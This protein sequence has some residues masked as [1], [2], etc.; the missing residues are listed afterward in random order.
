MTYNPSYFIDA[1]KLDH[2]RM[3]VPGTEYVYS[4]LTARGSR[5][6]GVDKVLFF[7]LQ[8]FLQ[9]VLIDMFDEWF[10]RDEDDVA[11]E[12]ERRTLGVIG[13]ND[14][15]VEHIRALHRLGY[16][17]LR[18]NAIPEGTEVPL[19]LPVFTLE[20]TDPE[21][22]WVTNYIETILSAETWLPSTSATIALNMR[23]LLDAWAEK[24][25][26][27]PD[28]V[29]FQG[30]D[31]S[32][33][34]MSSLDSAASSGAGH[35]LSFAGTDTMIALDWIEQYYPVAATA[36]HTPFLGGSVAASEHSVMCAGTP[37]G[38]DEEATYRRLLDLYP[39]GIVS[40][41]SDTYDL[42]KVL[43]ETLPALKD[44]IM[45]REGKLVIRPDSG[46][47]ADIL[48]GTAQPSIPV[49]GI[50]VIGA[51]EYMGER[52]FEEKGVIELL[53]NVFGGTVNAKGYKELDPH[54]GA[55]YGDSITWDRANDICAR[56]E[57]KGFA[58]TNVVF[59]IGSFT[60]QFNTRDTLGFAM[61]ATWA[62]IN[63]VGI[64]LFKDP[65]TD[66][67]LK[68]SAKGR[69]AV[70]ADDNGELHLVEQA[71]AQE[72]ERSLLVPVWENGKFIKKYTWNEVVDRVGV[73][74]IK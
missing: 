57:A 10:A 51:K 67:G 4:N 35:L 1:Y 34:G 36:E 70:L 25:S 42:W 19:R 62:Q 28:F 16:V 60:Y 66:S 48:C 40:L 12:Y 26:S 55:I 13:P 8:A 41:V 68:K 33:R 21:F 9:R 59:G 29:D 7:G 27:V 23:R 24:T 2:R 15:G 56:L 20:N 54:I 5:I 3:Y 71:N 14:I 50:A 49:P 45:N 37:D 18:F 11:E 31:F 58:S 47:P 64:D 74:K 38:D 63:G 17:P 43:T 65:V 52:S 73:R 69:L 44:E 32:F 53:W 61:K 6:P 72:E 30:H 39:T 46:D 22:F